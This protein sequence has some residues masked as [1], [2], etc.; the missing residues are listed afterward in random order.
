MNTLRPLALAAA[1]LL[2]SST[3]RAEEPA[4]PLPPTIGGATLAAFGLATVAGSPFCTLRAA[5]QTLCIVGTLL[6]G[7][8]SF[9]IAVPILELGAERRARARLGAVLAPG[10]V[11]WSIRW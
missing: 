5:G 6:A 8:A 2:V 11:A 10:L 3:V 9:G 4:S 7:M 1:L